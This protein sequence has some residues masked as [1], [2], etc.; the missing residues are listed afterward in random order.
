MR[1]YQ[2]F[3]IDA[4]TLDITLD[5]AKPWAILMCLDNRARSTRLGTDKLWPDQNS[6]ENP[7]F[8][9]MDHGDQ[10]TPPSRL[11]LIFFVLYTLGPDFV[12]IAESWIELQDLSYSFWR[13]LHMKVCL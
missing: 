11:D 7:N 1:G 13:R 8:R 3:A 5:L 12:F 4:K 2:N 6:L 10:H 9:N